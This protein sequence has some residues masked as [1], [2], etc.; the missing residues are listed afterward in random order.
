MDAGCGV[1]ATLR[2]GLS[3]LGLTYLAGV[4][5]STLAW[6]IVI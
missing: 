1:D 4:L 5:P 2:M 3:D 6:R